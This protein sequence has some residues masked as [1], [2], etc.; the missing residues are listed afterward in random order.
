[1]RT[2]LSIICLTVL[3]NSPLLA[4][5]APATEAKPVAETKELTPEEK[6]NETIAKLLRLTGAGEMGVQMMDQMLNQFRQLHPDVPNAFWDEFLADASV[7]GLEALIVP[8]YAKHFTQEE[9]D[10]LIEFY[11]SEIGRK[12]IAK[13][14]MIMQESFFAGQQWGKE[15]A[16]KV[17]KRLKE[18]GL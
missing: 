18:R 5:E 7:D 3:L 4:Q 8:I 11:E 6:K 17:V 9:L 16:D 10:A 12:L 1:M 14:P 13:Q 2:L 15:I